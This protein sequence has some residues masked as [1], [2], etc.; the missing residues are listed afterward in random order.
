M[1]RDGT[2]IDVSLWTAPLRNSKG[3]SVGDMGIFVDISGQKRMEEALLA[4]EANYRT[5]FNAVD[6]GIAVVDLETGNFLDVN[7]K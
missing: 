7:Q 6:E 4:S 1:R 5:I 2:M 3:E